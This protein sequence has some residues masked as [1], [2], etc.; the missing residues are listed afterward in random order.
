MIGTMAM[1][2]NRSIESAARPTGDDVPE[3]GSTMA[4]ED[5]ASARPSA[6]APVQYWPIMASTMAMMLPPSRS[7]SDPS[8]K[9]SRRICHKRRNDS[10]SPIVK[11]SRMIPNSAKGSSASGSVMVMCLSQ[12]TS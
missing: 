10:S 12:S 3:I 7:S 6:I 1:S 9:T 11:R 8:P 4:V 5:I 2:S